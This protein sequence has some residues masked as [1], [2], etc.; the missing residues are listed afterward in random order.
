MRPL[1]HADHHKFVEVEGWERKGTSRAASRVGDHH[2]YFLR[3]ANGDILR[4][5]VSHGSGSINDPHLVALIFREQLRVTEQQFYDCVERGV[6]PP[7]P[8]SQTPSLPEN[9]LD[10]KLVRNLIRKMGLSQEEVARLSRD[11]A[12]RIW[13]GYLDKSDDRSH[14]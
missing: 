7:R 4:T 10:A 1:R 6:L 11:E 2:R 5:R 14:G 3:L 12:L 8:Q 9:T 13:A